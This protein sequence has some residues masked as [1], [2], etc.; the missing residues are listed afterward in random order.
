MNIDKKLKFEEIS[1]MITKEHYYFKKG[2]TF[3]TE[4]LK[5]TRRDYETSMR[6][7]D[8]IFRQAYIPF[9]ILYDIDDERCIMGIIHIDLV[10]GSIGGVD[11]KKYKLSRCVMRLEVEERKSELHNLDKTFCQI[12]GRYIDVEQL[13]KK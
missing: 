2:V 3:Y 5:M 13:I 7:S 11:Y 8:P 10:S 9:Q 6:S 1:D 12:I 4:N